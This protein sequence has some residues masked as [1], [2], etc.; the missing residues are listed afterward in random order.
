M[1]RLSIYWISIDFYGCG[2]LVLFWA[3]R[4]AGGSWMDGFMVFV[5]GVDLERR[6]DG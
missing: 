1:F 5:L 6:D 2:C 3:K 4:N